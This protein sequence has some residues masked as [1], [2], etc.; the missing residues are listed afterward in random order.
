MDIPLDKQMNK[1]TDKMKE[2]PKLWVGT[3]K[4]N[5]VSLSIPQETQNNPKSHFNSPEGIV[6]RYNS[7]KILE[8]I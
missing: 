3:I 5:L 8:S 2:A 1:L 6:F 7:Q 4:G